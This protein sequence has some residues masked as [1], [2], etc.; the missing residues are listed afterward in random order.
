MSL[1][2]IWHKLLESIA[3]S[4]PLGISI[5][6]LS[7]L[8]YSFSTKTLCATQ[9][10]YM[11][12]CLIQSPQYKQS[13][14]VKFAPV[15]PTPN[16]TP[17]SWPD[18]ILDHS[19]TLESLCS[20]FTDVW[21]DSDQLSVIRVGVTEPV[22]KSF[23]GLD[24]AS[25]NLFV[26][27][28]R[29]SVLAAIALG[30]K[31]G[32]L[33][34]DLPSLCNIEH[35]GTKEANKT[36]F[37]LLKGLLETGLV[38][39][40][41]VLIKNSDS[42]NSTGVIRTNKLTLSKYVGTSEEDGDDVVTGHATCHYSLK[43]VMIEIWNYI[44]NDENAPFLVDESNED[45]NQSV[46]YFPLR[47]L[48]SKLKKLKAIPRTKFS[49][50]ITEL[51]D[52][53]LIQKVY[54]FIKPIR[55]ICIQIIRPNF[56]F[57]LVNSTATTIRSSIVE[58]SRLFDCSNYSHYNPVVR[59]QALVDVALA[60]QVMS[61]I[62]NV[63]VAPTI[64]GYS[65]VELSKLFKTFPKSLVAWGKD[66]AQLGLAKQVNVQ[67]GKTTQQILSPTSLSL[68][69]QKIYPNIS[70]FTSFELDLDL[71]DETLEDSLT[72]P[73]LS[74]MSRAHNQSQ[75]TP[76]LTE[77]SSK[78]NQKSSR[79]VDKSRKTAVQT[80]DREVVCLDTI[81]SEKAIALPLLTNHIRETDISGCRVDSRT[82]KNIVKRL[83]ENKKARLVE[84]PMVLRQ[85][86]QSTIDVIV[87]M[88]W[89][90]SIK[91]TRADDFEL[92]SLQEVKN[93]AIKFRKY[94][95][96]TPSKTLSK[97]RCEQKSLPKVV[98]NISAENLT[99]SEEE[100]AYE[101]IDLFSRKV[102]TFHSFLIENYVNNE[103][104][105]NR[106]RG[107]YDPCEFASFLT[108]RD[109]V[110]FVP[111]GPDFPSYSELIKLHGANIL[112]E[113]LMDLN[114]EH[115]TILC[116]SLPQRFSRLNSVLAGLNLCSYNNNSRF[117]E[118]NFKPKFSEIFK[119]D[120]I[121]NEELVEFI[122]NLDE[123]VNTSDSQSNF[124]WF[125]DNFELICLFLILFKI[126]FVNVFNSNQLSPFLNLESWESEHDDHVIAQL[127]Q[128]F[129]PN[130]D[131]FSISSLLSLASSQ[132]FEPKIT[133]KCFISLYSPNRKSRPKGLLSLMDL[134]AKGTITSRKLKPKISVDEEILVKNKPENVA[135][136]F[137]NFPILDNYLILAFTVFRTPATPQYPLGSPR[138]VVIKSFFDDLIARLLIPVDLEELPAGLSTTSFKVR[139]N[140]IFSNQKGYMLHQWVVYLIFYH[141]IS[142][143]HTNM[144]LNLEE[145]FISNFSFSVDFNYSNYLN[146]N[147]LIA[148]DFTP[149]ASITKLDPN[150]EGNFSHPLLGPFSSHFLRQINSEI[151]LNFLS[152]CVDVIFSILC[153][154]AIEV[155]HSNPEPASAD[156]ASSDVISQEKSL[157]HDLFQLTST[158]DSSLIDSIMNYFNKWSMI[159]TYTAV[160]ITGSSLSP[161]FD[162]SVF[163]HKLWKFLIENYVENVNHAKE[164]QS[165]LIDHLICE[166]PL[167]DSGSPLLMSSI[168]FQSVFNHVSAELRID[169]FNDVAVDQN[170]SNLMANLS[171]MMSEI[172]LNV[173][174]PL[175]IDEFAS[176]EFLSLG[177]GLDYS[178][179]LFPSFHPVRTSNH[180]INSKLVSQLKGSIMQL[181]LVD[182]LI[183]LYSLRCTFLVM[184]PR[185]L[186]YCLFEL[187]EDKVIQ[188]KRILNSEVGLFSA[189]FDTVLF[190]PVDCNLIVIEGLID[191]DNVDDMD[192]FI[193]ELI[194]ILPIKQSS[195]L[196]FGF[197]YSLAVE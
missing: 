3:F 118:L 36:V 192:S 33:Q 9:N 142:T 194:E 182:G 88:S 138:W 48:Y 101:L 17:D 153:H 65:S 55:R 136:F 117:F 157:L 30:K 68:S 25:S 71:D 67:I 115:K 89:L 130:F 100:I 160:S 128:N 164:Q 51:I 83:I 141:K 78:V 127:S 28:D 183:S 20:S 93:A 120:N 5:S 13:L 69:L 92:L 197:D 96:E 12:K 74:E 63:K 180:E 58:K 94:L 169:T 159:S 149:L 64:L 11:L 29:F 6:Q 75:S 50:A 129:G 8:I 155:L 108:L 191:P 18:V 14:W 53:G 140:Q 123:N 132:N 145:E 31:N 147:T 40:E 44:K 116:R 7:T 57:P 107:I 165:N 124:D 109:F 87:S 56:S 42:R 38:V 135:A 45:N 170:Q 178:P 97:T 144:Q 158:M 37:Y 72:F 119:F 23:I 152:K 15:I 188:M 4:G 26:S 179:E 27:P 21:P 173:K 52:L 98:L 70:L 76:L 77:K 105:S 66:L 162:C 62:L 10:F 134:T 80:S 81:N 24:T 41:P 1:Q 114:A 16:S 60:K 121:T 187:I 151:E 174:Q 166:L 143:L 32:V 102:K 110:S 126:N 90:S 49:Q 150:I 131:T 122:K 168:L 2:A 54:I 99:E 43:Q 177:L 85:S 171:G 46:K 61:I 59:P 91:R 133:L 172:K 184:S 193:I 47:D 104:F 34:S 196:L 156:V 106:S 19:V 167:N 22:F 146:N 190:S 39:K 125:W 82:I 181:L 139:I 176:N 186:A 111:V 79:N 86:N 154:R 112:D 137:E 189:D 103:P 84:F 175:I 185:I 163:G 148:R 35:Q 73:D 95:R 195:E 113:F 161:F